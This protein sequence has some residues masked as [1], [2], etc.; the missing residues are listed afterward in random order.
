MIDPIKILRRAWYILWNYRTLWVFGLILALA[1]A[2]S[3]TGGNNGMQFHS[4]ENNPQPTPQS[5]QEFF[6]N[7]NREIEKLFNQGIPEI[8]ISG[9]MLTTFLWVIGVFV[10]IMLV[11]GI[12]VAIARYVSETAVI[13]MVDEYE[14]TGVKMT[15][16]EGFRIGWS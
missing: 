3:S 7:L 2:G 9:E 1:T 15:V 6:R 12:I 10:V 16:R 8:D 4:D 13:G 11:V 14:S 5:M